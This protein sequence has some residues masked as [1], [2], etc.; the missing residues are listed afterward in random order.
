[1]LLLAGY[2]ALAE[3]SKAT[4]HFGCTA[5][6]RVAVFKFGPWYEDGKGITVDLMDAI[7][8]RT[9]C[10]IK[11]VEISRAEAW[12]AIAKDEI[13]L[14]PTSIQTRERY[15]VARFVTFLHIRNLLIVRSDLEA[16]AATLDHFVTNRNRR[17]GL[18]NGFRYGSHFDLRLRS[19]LG[20]DRT[21]SAEDPRQLVDMLRQGKVDAILMPSAHYFSYVPEMERQTNFLVLDTSASMP[22][23]S[24]FA[25]SRSTFSS[26]QTDNWLRLIESMFLDGSLESILARHLPPRIAATITKR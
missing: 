9:G 12:A 21:L 7:R 19:L 1:M 2:P 11:L 25:L 5:E 8:Q 6:I 26:L 22:E 15:R 16:S 14:I 10:R 4:D 23:P 18:I 24:G 3:S 20:D 17:I 13:D